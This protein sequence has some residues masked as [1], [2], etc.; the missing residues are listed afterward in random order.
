MRGIA[1]KV[2]ETFSLTNN[3]RD[4]WK[5]L[6]SYGNL[7]E[8]FKKASKH[9]TVKPYVQE[10]E[11]NLK[12]NLIQLRIDL[13]FYSYRPKPL[14]T[15]ILHDPKTRTISKSAFRDRIVHHALCNIIEPLF[16]KS[17]I[18]DSYA[19]RKGKGVLKAI[20]RFDFF[21]QKVSKNGCKH[22]FVLKADVSHYFDTVDHSILLEIVKKKVKDKR[23]IWLIKQILNNYHTS[24]GRG[25]P[26]G[27]LTSQFFANVYLNELDQYVKHKLQIKYYIRY[28]DDFVILH[29]S[30]MFLEGL[31]E[32]IEEYLSNNLSLKLHK[33]KTKVIPMSRGVGFLGFKLFLYHRLLKKKNK[34]KF[35]RK[36]RELEAIYIKRKGNYN[37]IYDSLEGWLAHAKHANT[38]KIRTKVVEQFEKKYSTEISTKEVNRYL[39]NNL[40]KAL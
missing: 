25:M 37:V 15:F 10:F 14:E 17:F 23:I 16:E 19:N 35:L 22:F 5:E 1:Q 32:R 2:A 13:L 6:C 34:R 39:K 9:K 21:K 29:N 30:K 33:E 18:W 4:L 38:F 24:Q 20:Q 26:L 7:L 28:V 8:A 12:G 11:K 36:M 27:N 31:K 40:A 3:P